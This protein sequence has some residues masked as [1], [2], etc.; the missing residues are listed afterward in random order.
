M[1]ALCFLA[2]DRA[3]EISPWFGPP[4]LAGMARPAL[5]GAGHR[6]DGAPQH[7]GLGKRLVARAE[8]L[9]TL[10]GSACLPAMALPASLPACVPACLRARAC[11][12]LSACQHARVMRA[13]VRAVC[14]L[15]CMWS[16]VRTRSCKP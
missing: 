3:G 11:A 6:E 7:F 14:G 9:A 16:C 1:H 4:G 13:R 5:S 8:E 10:A 12:C 2:R 15:A